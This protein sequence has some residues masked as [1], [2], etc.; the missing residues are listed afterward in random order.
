MV[1]GCGVL[2]EELVGVVDVVDGD[3]VVGEWEVLEVAVDDAESEVAVGV[4]GGPHGSGIDG[5]DG[6]AEA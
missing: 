2:S 6:V 3:G 4:E 1:L 5:Q